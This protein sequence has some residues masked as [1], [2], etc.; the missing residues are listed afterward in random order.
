M[1]GDS[2]VCCS[3][4]STCAAI[5]Y[6]EHVAHSDNK[7]LRA[8]WAAI[9]SHCAVGKAPAKRIEALRRLRRHDS[10]RVSALCAIILSRCATVKA[11]AQHDSVHCPS[12]A[13]MTLS[14]ARIMRDNT[15]ALRNDSAHC[16]CCAKTLA[17][18]DRSRDVWS[19]MI[20][21]QERPK[22]TELL[23]SGPSIAAKYRL[24]RTI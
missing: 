16:E 14:F 19:S 24:H 1:S 17:H 2:V 20:G 10:K 8:L 4:Q 23:T 13:S 7:R 3:G 21:V 18:C 6:H 12:C 11:I 9:Q 15:V 22:I 5:Y